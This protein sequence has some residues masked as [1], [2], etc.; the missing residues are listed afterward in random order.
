MK[1]LTTIV[2]GTALLVSAPA[3]AADIVIGVPNWASVNATAHVLEIVIEEN[4]GLDVEL[5]NGTNPIVFEAMDKG[6]MH[7]HP[8][9]WM[10]NQQNLH[11]TY[12]KDNGSVVMNQN[13][14]SAE[15]GMCVPSYIAEQY[16]IKTIDDLSD[17]DKMAVFD[18]DGNGTP[19]VWIGAPG[20]ASTVVEKI[21]AKSYGYAET[22]NLMEM[23][24]ALALAQVDNAVAQGEN[25]VFY[26]YTPHH[27]FSLYD[28]VP[29]SEPS[30]D[31]AE[32]DVKQPTDDPN[33]L[34]N[35]KA[36]TAW[37]A[38]KLHVFYAGALEEAQ[39]EAAE[40]LSKVKL[41]TDQVNAI[42]FA[43]SADGKDPAEYAREWVDANSDLVDSWFN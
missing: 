35:S 30:Y 3:M 39:P 26:C 16:D 25:I 22:M 19:E 37:D 13:P 1:K 40:M 6:S 18:S 14:V 15:Q 10:P 36:G 24:E 33:W 23:D 41:T 29:L 27:M 20:W 4:L 32:W 11:D 7:A 31:A 42:V 34:E 5:Q 28:L 12:V 9:V 2:S 21:R 38:A 8:E 17:P 43:L